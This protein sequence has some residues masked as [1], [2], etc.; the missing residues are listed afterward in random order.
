MGEYC[1][2]TCSPLPPSLGPV[3][4]SPVQSSPVQSCPVQSSPVQSSPVQSSPVQSSPVQQASPVQESSPVQSSPVQSSPVQSSPVQNPTSPT[5]PQETFLL[6]LVQVTHRR[7]EGTSGKSSCTCTFQ[8]GWLIPACEPEARPPPTPT[9]RARPPLLPPPH[10][11]P[12]STDNGTGFIK[13]PCRERLACRP[14]ACTR[15][16]EAR[17]SPSRHQIGPGGLHK[18]RTRPRDALWPGH[19]REENAIELYDCLRGH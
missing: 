11:P 18:A 9:P 14:C 17:E 15:H 19:R 4:S 7:N 2:Y 16:S 5:G 13:S 3:Q 12:P 8:S 6:L 1:A 10:A